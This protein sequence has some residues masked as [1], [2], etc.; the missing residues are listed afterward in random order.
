MGGAQICVK[1]LVEN[2]SADSIESF[3]YP[4]RSSRPAIQIKST[5]I[6]NTYF[7]YDPRKLL[8][9]LKI[10]RQYE[11]D[12]IHAHLEKSVIAAGLASFFKKIP[13]VVHEH[14]PI[15]RSG[16]KYAVYRSFLKLF[17][18]NVNT[19]IAVSQYVARQLIQNGIPEDRIE[20][21]YN[22]V[23]TEVFSFSESIARALRKQFVISENTI[24][25]GFVGRLNKVKGVDLLIRSI[26]DLIKTFPKVV[27]LI[28]GDGPE[29]QSLES[30]AKDLQIDDRVRFLGNQSNIHEIMNVFDIGVIPSRQEPMGIIAIELMS[31]K[32]PIV[33]SGVDGLGEM[34]LDTQ[35]GLIASPN[36]PDQICGCMCRLLNH[37]E[38]R[39]KTVDSASDFVQNFRLSN[40]IQA[41]ERVYFNIVKKS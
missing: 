22:S 21:I 9:I 33:S 8:H 32:V 34:I 10:C 41:V 27:L 1:R 3:V 7:N 2:Y 19:Y 23:D 39:H 6:T 37:P 16:W 18:K 14:G 13:V 29:R 35:T 12:I 28:V 30:L 24:V 25:V 36:S 40:Q 15:C 31:M 17:G 4:L 5:V 11:I 38:L 26:S 20:V